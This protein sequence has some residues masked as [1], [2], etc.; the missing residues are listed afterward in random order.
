M[1]FPAEIAVL[2]HESCALEILEV[3]QSVFDG[4]PL[5]D[6]AVLT[7]LDVL[8][9]EGFYRVFYRYFD[10]PQWPLGQQ[11]SKR[12]REREREKER[13][14]ERQRDRETER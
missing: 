11:M 12:G 6:G 2:Q 7:N 8:I 14:R 10:L 13:A 3:E 1:V 9:L 5:P 4:L